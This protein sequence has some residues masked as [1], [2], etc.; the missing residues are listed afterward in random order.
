VFITHVK[1]FFVVLAVPS[2]GEDRAIVQVVSRR[3]PTAE[4]G[5]GH[6]GFVVDKAELGQV[7]PEYLGLRCHFAFHR[8][9]HNHHHPELVQ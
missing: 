8:L 4:A 6:V 3:L 9:L 5:S 7:L 1:Y 2:D